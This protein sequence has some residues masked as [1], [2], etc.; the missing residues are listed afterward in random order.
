MVPLRMPVLHRANSSTKPIKFRLAIGVVPLWLYNLL[1]PG[2]F[3]LGKTSDISSD[4]SH[5]VSTLQ[6]RGGIG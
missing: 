3:L 2:I 4:D 1:P 6:P 5:P